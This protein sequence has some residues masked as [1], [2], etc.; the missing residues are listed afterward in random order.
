[1]SVESLKTS[2]EK[3]FKALLERY[4]TREIQRAQMTSLLFTFIL[5]LRD[6][7]WRCKMEMLKTSFRYEI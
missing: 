3:S 4:F 1:M 7:N 5:R 6:D 2:L